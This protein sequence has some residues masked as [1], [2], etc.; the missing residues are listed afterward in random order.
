MDCTLPAS[1]AG[2]PA[3]LY[4]LIDSVA[5]PGA[6]FWP[7]V[8]PR[9]AI[10]PTIGLLLRHGSAGGARSYEE[11][12]RLATALALRTAERIAIGQRRCELEPFGCPLDLQA[13]KPIPREVLLRGYGD[14]GRDWLVENWGVDRPL[15]NVDLRVQTLIEAEKQGRGRPRAGSSAPR[16][17]TRTTAVWTFG[18]EAFPWGC[19]RGLLKQWPGITFGVAFEDGFGKFE[20]TWPAIQI[21]QE[22]RAA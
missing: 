10:E 1:V 3:P 19:F 22:K 4:A 14:G 7:D 11:A 18:T 12:R 6:V 16:A 17:W 15:A 13:I 20:K 5:G 8:D 9:A 2:D 21:V